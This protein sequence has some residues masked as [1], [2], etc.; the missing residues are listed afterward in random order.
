MGDFEFFVAR[1]TEPIARNVKALHFDLCPDLGLKRN[2]NLKILIM[3]Y[4]CDD[5][6][7][8]RSPAH[9][10]TTFNFGDSLG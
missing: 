5:K 4:V 6:G 3:D 7:F 9:L 8:L 1:L 10:D 2:L